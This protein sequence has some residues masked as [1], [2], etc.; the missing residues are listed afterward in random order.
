MSEIWT[1]DCQECGGSGEVTVPDY[2]I[3]WDPYEID[4]PTCH[5]GKMML[6]VKC[7]NSE[8]GGC[9]YAEDGTCSCREGYRPLTETDIE[10]MM[11]NE[12]P[13]ISLNSITKQIAEGKH[14]TYKGQPVKLGPAEGV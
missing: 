9:R 6:V 14:V 13:H 7:E 5:K 4:C 11:I 3:D 8:D 12:Y 1:T 2:H 10:D